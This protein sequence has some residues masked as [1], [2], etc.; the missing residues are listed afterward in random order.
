MNK[1]VSTIAPAIFAAVILIMAIGLVPTSVLA[2]NGGGHY[3]ATEAALRLFGNG[4]GDPAAPG[5]PNGPD[6]MWSQGEPDPMWISRDRDIPLY[7]ELGK[8][9]NWCNPEKG[10]AEG[11][12]DHENW[13]WIT[14]CSMKKDQ[15]DGGLATMNHFWYPEEGLHECPDDVAGRNNAWEEMGPHWYQALVDWLNGNLGGA[16]GNLGYAIHLIQD[17]G[18]PA[19]SNEDMHPG[20]DLGDDDCLEDWMSETYVKEHF[21]WESNHTFPAPYGEFIP[22]L[23]SNEQIS[24]DVLNAAWPEADGDAG[25]ENIHDTWVED[26]M[27]TYETGLWGWTQVFY[28]MYFLSQI[29]GYFAS[30]S[31]SGN[32]TDPTGWLNDFPSFPQYLHKGDGTEVS[33][34]NCTG[35]DPDN[36]G[37][38]QFWCTDND[39]DHDGD[40]S[41]IMDYAYGST[42]R[43]TPGLLDLFRRTVDNVPPVT[44][45]DL[46]RYDGEEVKLP[47][48]WNNWP[49]TVEL[50]GA[51]DQGNPWIVGTTRTMS[52]VWKVWGRCDGLPPDDPADSTPSWGI[53][54]D[55]KHK[56]ECM[57]TDWC[58]N[59]EQDQDIEI[60]IDRT[61]PEVT[62]PGLRPNYL[63]SETFTATWVATDALSGVASEV[64]YLDGNLVTK[65]QVFDLALLAGLHTLRVIAYD[66]A[67]NLSDVNY[68]FEVWIDAD[69]WC[70]SVLVNNKTD[71]NAMTCSVEFPA[72]Y[73]VGLIS[74]NTSTLAVKGAIDLTQSDPVVGKTAELP[75]KLLTGVGDNDMDGILDRKI[76]FRKDR[77]VSAL[78]GQTGNIPSIIRG[79][80]LPNGQPRFIA[81]VIVPVFK[82]TKK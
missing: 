15:I 3:W 62:F 53:S 27:N 6:P 2:W 77:F 49:V 7:P 66:N 78:G 73:N 13:Y 74:L 47:P 9:T 45:Y 60:W 12:E 51:T 22:P 68:N 39:N 80:L 30:D 76:L 37:C 11:T 5:D 26:T 44:T 10:C 63:T 40:L 32:N 50:T 46:A 23:K 34:Q 36:D 38:D 41:T 24:S 1:V 18:Q 42:F 20:N 54:T 75:A 33:A 48:Q 16:Y 59:V 72:P 35:L 17:P 25:E 56:V 19:H 64:A 61:P 28:R 21:K 58:G 70:F 4:D 65:G 79:G 29:G 8:V 43:M 57:S 52:G 31:H 69:G 67:G 55:G 81:E 14:I 82:S 71:G